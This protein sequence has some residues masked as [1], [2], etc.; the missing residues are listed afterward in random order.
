MPRNI[1]FFLQLKKVREYL[2]VLNEPLD[3][4][5]FIKKSFYIEQ[6]YFEELTDLHMKI[7]FLRKLKNEGCT[8]TLNLMKKL[9]KEYNFKLDKNVFFFNRIYN[10]K[11]LFLCFYDGR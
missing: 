10:G 4:I 3:Y 6:N 1:T 11:E 2:L 9:R 8:K 5:N 7:L